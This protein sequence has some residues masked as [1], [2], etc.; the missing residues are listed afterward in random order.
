M[1]VEGKPELTKM[2]KNRIKSNVMLQDMWDK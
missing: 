1:R 2:L